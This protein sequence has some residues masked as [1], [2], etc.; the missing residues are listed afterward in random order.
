MLTLFNLLTI[1]IKNHFEN[2]GYYIRDWLC[3]AVL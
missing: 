2:C 1:N 3:A